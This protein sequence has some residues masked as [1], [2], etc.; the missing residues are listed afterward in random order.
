MATR[1]GHSGSGQLERLSRAAFVPVKTEK[2]VK[3]FKPTEVYFSNK[4]GEDSLF[5][6]AFTFVDFGEK[7][8]AFLRYCGVRSEPSVKGESSC[9]NATQ[10]AGLMRQI[11]QLCLCENPRGCFDKLAHLTSKLGDNFI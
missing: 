10:Q 3:L 7:A 4:S 5:K 2:D 6:S 1:A 8:N 9:L 11:S